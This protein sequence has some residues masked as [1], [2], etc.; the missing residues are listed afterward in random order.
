VTYRA[1]PADDLGPA[2]FVHNLIASGLFAEPSDDLEKLLGRPATG[3]RDAVV[4]A[5]G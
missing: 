3:M 1:V 2:A 4:A 5:L